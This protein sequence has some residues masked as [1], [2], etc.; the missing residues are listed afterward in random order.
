MIIESKIEI[1][2]PIAQVWKVLSDLSNYKSWNSFTPRIDAD[3]SQIGSDVMLHV[4][5]NPDS[6]KLLR[7]KETLL[8]FDPQNHTMCWGIDNSRLFLRTERIQ[9]LTAIDAQSTSYYTSDEFWGML[10]P[11]V[12]F[13]YKSKVQRGFD[14]VARDLKRYCESTTT[15][16][17]G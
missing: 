5:M 15:M 7:Q 10:T 14:A 17:A 13:F 1:Q 12:S 6:E 4:R 2:A 11:L 16:Q 3:F 9:R 8:S